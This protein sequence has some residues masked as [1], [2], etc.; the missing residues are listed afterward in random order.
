MGGVD[1]KRRPP[2]SELRH[3]KLDRKLARRREKLERKQLRD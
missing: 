3:R 2:E 1:V